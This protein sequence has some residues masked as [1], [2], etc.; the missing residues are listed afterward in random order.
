MFRADGL[1]ASSKHIFTKNANKHCRQKCKQSLMAPVFHC[2]V[3]LCDH[4]AKVPAQTMT[5]KEMPI[6]KYFTLHLSA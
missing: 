1:P 5:I 2:T 6:K 3:L 4:Q